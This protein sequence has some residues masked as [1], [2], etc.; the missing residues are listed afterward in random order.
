MGGHECKQGGC[1]S[2]K[3]R[4]TLGFCSL[5][6]STSRLTRVHTCVDMLTF[7]CT[8]QHMFTHVMGIAV[9]VLKLVPNV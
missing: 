4:E 7:V 6:T 8:C 5:Q 1:V 2:A 9:A 3:G